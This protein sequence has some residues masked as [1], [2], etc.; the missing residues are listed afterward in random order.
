MENRK[1]YQEGAK[2][3]D[4]I[5]QPTKKPGIPGIGLKSNSL[6]RNL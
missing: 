2:M 6:S 1:N 3:L 5:G 4:P